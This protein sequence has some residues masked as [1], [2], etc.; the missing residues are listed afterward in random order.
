MDSEP[1]TVLAA[2]RRYL[3]DHPRASDGLDGVVRWWLGGHY[4]PRDVEA[5][6]LQLQGEG[7]V[8]RLSASDGRV[9]WRRTA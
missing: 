4:A 5:A 8:E 9:R 6:L 2:L 1:A 3:Q 7:L